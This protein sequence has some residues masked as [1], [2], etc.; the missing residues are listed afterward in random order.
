MCSIVL[1][2][3]TTIR[4]WASL[5]CFLSTSKSHLMWNFISCYIHKSYFHIFF[6]IQKFVSEGVFV[7]MVFMG[8]LLY[9][10]CRCYISISYISTKMSFALY[11]SLVTHARSLFTPSHQQS[12]I[13]G[14]QW[15]AKIMFVMQL[16]Y[17][18]FY[19]YNIRNSQFL[20]FNK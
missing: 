17:P 9:T 1:F 3:C 2:L 11:C 16:E 7:Y 8:F 10:Y 12:M 15:S 19:I 13:Y 4:Y 5:L 18:V 14:E 6:L 20:I